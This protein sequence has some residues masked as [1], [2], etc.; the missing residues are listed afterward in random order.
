MA[1][2]RVLISKRFIIKLKD[3]YEQKM[4]EEFGLI[5]TDSQLIEIALCEL[6]AYKKNKE[7]NIG[8]TKKGKRL[9]I[10]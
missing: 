1:K 6:D 7:I 3:Q 5:P 9:I 8:F 4:I 2:I 10:K